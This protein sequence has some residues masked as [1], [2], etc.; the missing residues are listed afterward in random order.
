M[1]NKNL[2]IGKNCLAEVLKTS[3]ERILKIYTSHDEKDPLLSKCKK[4]VIKKSKKFLDETSNST[5]HQGYM[6]EVT[7]RPNY[8]IEDLIERASEKSLIIILDSI[9]DPQNVGSILRAGECFGVDGF[10]ISKNKGCK[11]TPTVTKT[12]VGASELVPIVEASNLSN[13]VEKLKKHGYWVIS[14]AVDKKAQALPTFDFPEKSVL[15]LGSE[16]NGI[17]KTLLKHSDFLVYIPM[18]GQIDSLNVSQA[19]SV[20][21][22]FFKK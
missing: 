16:G 4:P 5:S 15:I 10:I 22:S 3:P 14:S 1:K 21:C 6:A 19:A 17:Q 18:T 20:F 9:F 8:C 7:P 11:I 2:I 13:A 12:S